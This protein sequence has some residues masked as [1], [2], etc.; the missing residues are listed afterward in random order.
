[1][2]Y[3]GEDYAD[4]YATHVWKHY[5]NHFHLFKKAFQKIYDDFR[6]G[7]VGTPE[8]PPQPI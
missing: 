8:T 2:A 6:V 4:R 1:M 3:K 7:L 5:T